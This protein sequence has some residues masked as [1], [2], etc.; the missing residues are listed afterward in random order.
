MVEG[1]GDQVVAHVG[2][3]A[4]GAFADRLGL[5]DSLS[6]AIPVSGERALL[7]DR[8]KVLVQAM[9]MLAGGGEA[10]ADIEHLR[11]QP[12]LFGSVASDSTLYRSVR[13]IDAATLQGL[14][15][16]MAEVRARV[17][18]RSSATTGTA[19]VVVDIDSSLHQIHS[20]HKAQAAPNYKGG[21]G[22]H[23]IY[24]FADATGETLAVKLRPGNAGANTIADH[25]A[26]LDQA[27]AQLPAEIAA[28]HHDGDD[29]GLV[30]RGV[31]VRCDSAG[32]TDFVWHCRARNVGF[33]V[34]ARSNASIH[35]AISAVADDDGRWQPAVRQNGDDRGGAAVCELT[36]VVDLSDWP[37]GTRLIVRREPLLPGAQQT[38]FP[39]MLF[40]YWGHYTDAAG[41][42]VT[43]DVHMRAHAHV[44]DH[45][46]RLKDSGADRF[47][48]VDI[49]ANRA[50]LATVCF[51]DALV[52]WFQLLCLTGS[53]TVAEP[54]TLRWNLWHTPAR[55][56]RRARRHIVRILDGWPTADELL[57][58]Y[59]RVALIT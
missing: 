52:R 41:D 21:Y 22:F 7:H 6:A 30:R 43:L 33:A 8:G 5:G 32:C 4:L 58:A 31:Q 50:W 25:V 56:V 51:A 37:A 47:P 54:K 10:C 46:R 35:A 19:T 1:G 3:H 34:V 44:E 42:P 12:A 49:D 2:L 14:W 9:L 18:R 36:E 55:I 45:I 53:L 11:S 48:F 38:L 27:L 20:E 39:S 57:A 15:E 23:P 16:A 28:G 40:R 29:P 26:V 13:A 17:W 59:Q 24:C